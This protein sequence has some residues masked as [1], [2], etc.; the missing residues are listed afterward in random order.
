M[1]L[2]TVL[3]SLLFFLLLVNDNSA[4]EK[5]KPLYLRNDVPIAQRL[6]D[7]MQRMTL[8]EKV[9][10]MCQYVG[11]EHQRQTARM[12]FGEDIN[13]DDAHG[14]YKDLSPADVAQMVKQGLIGSFLH[15]VTLE[16]ANELQKLALQS[17]LKIPLLIGIDAI[18]GNA[19][20][21]GATVY[22]TPLTLA[23]SWQPELVQQVGQQTALEMRALG[24]HWTF[25][26]NVDV[27]RDP[28]WGRVGETF[29]E[30]PF[31][32]GKM[33]V[34][35]IRGLQQDN[36]APFQNVIACAK[37][38]VGGGEPLNGINAAPTDVS[39]LT[40]YQ[41]FFPPFWEAIKAGAYTV[42]AAHNEVEG[43]PCHG[44]RF[45]LTDVLRKQMGFNGFVV[46]DWMDI[47]RLH[48][49]HH[50]A[51]DLND[52]F[53]LAVDAGV[54]MHMHGPKFLEGVVELVQQG[55]LSEA[56]I[57]QAVR[58]ILKAKFQLGLFEQPLVNA[59]QAEKIVFNPKHQKLALQA[60]RESIVL[61]K[62]NG[63]LPLP[64]NKPLKILVTG[65]NA[66]NQTLLGD[67]TL[68][69]P[70]EKVITVLEGLQQ[71]KSPSV[72]IEF[73]D[74]GSN[75]LQLQDEKIEQ[76]AQKAGEADVNIVVV[77]SNSLR[78]QNEAKT[79]GENVDRAHIN[80]AGKQRQ[81]VQKIVATGKPVVV[82]LIN[83]RPLAEP[84][85]VDQVDALIE[86]WE[87][88]SFGGKALAEIIFGKVNPSGKLPVTI[89]RNEGQIQM[90][91]NYKPSMYF[92]HYL[93]EA[94]SPLFPFGFGL[95]YT[96][97]DIRDLRVEPKQI[98][99]DD[100]VSVTVRLKNNG[101]RAGKEVV[102][103][104]L[105]D[106]VSSLTRPIKELKAFR[107]IE[108]K[109]GEERVV[110][111]QLA[112]RALGFFDGNGDYRLEP[113]WFTVMVGN[114]SADRDLLKAR[115]ELVKRGLKLNE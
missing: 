5:I 113:G 99:F 71:E 43:Q 85:M 31:L 2:K 104:Y 109:A 86:A 81:L 24:M 55:K 97:F 27:A 111:F 57:N 110:R 20:V 58:A 64:L 38:F 7:L 77:G 42:M 78:Y 106:E 91:Y 114:S 14:F 68:E 12:R 96:S 47:E 105:R 76:A 37:H 30:D 39:R 53:R 69:Q 72:D 63:L 19:L 108:L 33:G 36:A 83:S 18:H 16:E 45:L 26:P 34:A 100:T 89:P 28:R 32:V 67:W 10:Q 61:L 17:R 112:A 90:V 80:L 101:P 56:R 54:D 95:S 29:G 75:I 60:A 22:P 23:S 92:H 98:G 73:F 84:W 21:R 82:V 65:P 49:L 59:E 46:S 70:E 13:A 15:V 1:Y 103:L 25:T 4:Q 88:G 62:N 66:N 35:M 3:V 87:P 52:A 48:T 51:A 50:V 93:D 41:I 94:E 40:L 9:G 6:D 107:K 79:S 102:Q 115:F 8:H 74:C 11:L 44:S